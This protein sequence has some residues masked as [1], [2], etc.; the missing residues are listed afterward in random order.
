MWKA[1]ALLIALHSTYARY[2]YSLGNVPHSEVLNFGH[3]KNEL[4]I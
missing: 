2:L 4:T 3:V 1:V